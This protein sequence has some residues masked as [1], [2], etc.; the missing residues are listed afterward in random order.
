MVEIM[1]Y[2]KVPTTKGTVIEPVY[3]VEDF[4]YEILENLPLVRKK[5]GKNKKLE[6]YNISA[7]FDI[8]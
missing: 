4:P 5:Q 2:I 1:E 7:S 6:Y 8:D 3:T